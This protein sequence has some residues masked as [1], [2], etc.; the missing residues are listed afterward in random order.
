MEL[1]KVESSI[2]DLKAQKNELAAKSLD[3]RKDLE[4]LT[5]LEITEPAAM[6]MTGELVAAPY[7]GE[8]IAEKETAAARE[9]WQRSKSAR[10]PGLYLT[11]SLSG[12]DGEAY[13]TDELIYRD[14]G[15]IGLTIQM[16]LFDQTL[17]VEQKI[18]QSRLHKAEKEMETTRISLT[19]QEK[20]FKGKLPV[21]EES[22]AIA[23]QSLAN[24]EQILAVARLSLEQGRTTTEEYL[25][26]RGIGAG[27]PRR[28]LSG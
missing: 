17:S 4:T 23:T 9:E 2:N 8:K 6:I 7:L 1:L 27:R 16:P 12:N 25:R 22:R 26:Q 10:Y 3:I 13:N 21:V 14:Y 5:G 18:A 15:F 19:A 20:N 11:G 28:P 24:S